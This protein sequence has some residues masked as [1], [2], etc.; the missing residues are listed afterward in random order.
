MGVANSDV[1]YRR[2]FALTT[3]LSETGA[4]SELE[5]WYYQNSVL[6]FHNKDTSGGQTGTLLS[7]WAANEMKYFTF[8][9]DKTVGQ[10][11][12]YV[13]GV[14]VNTLTNANYT[15]G[16]RYLQ[17][18]RNNQAGDYIFDDF[19]IFPTALSAQEI[20]S[21]YK[22]NAPIQTEDKSSVLAASEIFPITSA[23]SSKLILAGTVAGNV[24]T[25]RRGQGRNWMLEVRQ[26]FLRLTLRTIQIL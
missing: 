3:V 22:S 24:G 12:S 26:E 4:D 2:L 9:W 7:S 16:F 21:I 1:T 19:A 25:G 10:V 6:T 20:Y 15:A 5:A 23:G 8:T 14:L 11:K 18:S 17:T 13:N